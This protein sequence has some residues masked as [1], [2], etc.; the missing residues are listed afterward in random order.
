MI[1]KW[2]EEFVVNIC[3][4]LYLNIFIEMMMDFS[5]I[6]LIIRYYE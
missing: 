5:K 4:N 2:Y 1:F 3:V 6:K